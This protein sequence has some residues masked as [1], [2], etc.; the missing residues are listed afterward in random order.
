MLV[1]LYQA[2]GSEDEAQTAMNRLDIQSKCSL[3]QTE[4]DADELWERRDIDCSGKCGIFASLISA[5]TKLGHLCT[6]LAGQVML[7]TEVLDH[8]S[9]HPRV[10]NLVSVFSEHLQTCGESHVSPY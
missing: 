3:L 6:R 8:P 2:C 5:R 10:R 1:Q 9:D 4:L 7:L